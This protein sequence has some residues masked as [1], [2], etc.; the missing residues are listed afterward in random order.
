MALD[1]TCQICA[2]A[3]TKIDLSVD[4]SEIEDNEIKKL[5]MYNYGKAHIQCFQKLALQG[6]DCEQLQFFK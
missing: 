4:L 5:L 2:Q 6:P 3:I 1:K